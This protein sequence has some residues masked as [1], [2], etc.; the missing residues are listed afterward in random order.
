M[1]S[2][3][4]KKRTRTFDKEQLN[5]PEP[6][7][8]F[9]QSVKEAA[10][11][12]FV[13]YKQNDKILTE[14]RKK[15]DKNGKTLPARGMAVRGQLHDK[16]FY[17]K[18]KE[19][20][21]SE[22]VKRDD[23]KSLSVIQLRNIVD[24]KVKNVIIETI[25]HSTAILKDKQGREKPISLDDKEALIF[26]KLL[27]DEKL[28][29]EE[30]KNE[31]QIKEKVSKMLKNLNFFMPNKGKRYQRLKKEDHVFERKPVPIKKVRVKR[32]LKNAKFLKEMQGLHLVKNE[33]NDYNQYVDP[34]NNHHVSIYRTLDGGL[35]EKV[36]PFWDAIERVKQGEEAIDKKPRDGNVFVESLEKNELFLFKG[37]Y[38]KDR[39]RGIIEDTEIKDA[40]YAMLSKYL[41]R[42][43][44]VSSKYYEFRH[45]LE[46]THNR[47]FRPYYVRIQS[48]GQ[49]VTGW[50]T[51]NPIKVKI[52]PANK[53]EKI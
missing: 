48:F 52:T 40:D 23:V 51:F 9:H 11:M 41:Y 35:T 45:H 8:N 37:L 36:V 15:I 24:E 3:K 44:A 1:L 18:N 17:G 42:C 46:S 21:N 29:K 5:F 28:S 50:L 20:Q 4:E 2:E 25:L 38:E 12:I 30:K 16:T 19:C 43:E 26:K 10:E 49:G 14:V 39:A 27:N 47:E 32:I 6:W 34:G 33:A 31:K 13:S 22:Y 7:N 53:I